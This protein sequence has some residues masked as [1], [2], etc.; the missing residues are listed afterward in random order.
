MPGARIL[1]PTERLPT[2]ASTMGRGTVLH[3]SAGRLDEGNP[4]GSKTIW[5]MVIQGVIMGGRRKRPHYQCKNLPRCGQS[6]KREE[7][8]DQVV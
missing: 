3:M 8:G 7:E 4:R 2:R 6:G 5:E 1:G